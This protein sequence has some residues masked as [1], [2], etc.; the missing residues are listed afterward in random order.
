MNEEFIDDGYVKD[1]IVFNVKTEP[2]LT[3]DETVRRH[4]SMS[5]TVLFSKKR[6]PLSAEKKAELLKEFEVVCVNDYGDEYHMSEEERK[7]KFQ[8]Y[9]AF[10]KIIR[11]KRKYRK[12]DEFVKV[13][14]LCMD[15]LEIVANNNGV[16][17]PEKFTQ[18]VLKGDIVVSGLNFPKYIGKD[19]KTINW[20]YVTEFITDRTLDPKELV[21]KR[22]EEEV[23]EDN[24]EEIQK[25]L[26]TDEEVQELLEIL[27]I[28][29]EDEIITFYDPDD[30]NE[31]RENIAVEASDKEVRSLIKMDP[32]IL[33]SVKEYR[34]DKRRTNQMNR[35][36]SRLGYEYAYDDYEAIEEMDKE[37][38]IKSSGQIPDVSGDMLNDKE[39]KKY[40]RKLDDYEN[41][42]IKIN[43]HGKMRSQ[44]EI[45]EIELKNLLEKSGWN[46]KNMFSEQGSISRKKLKKQRK[47]DK[48]R[49]EQLKK[50]LIQVQNRLGKKDTIDIGGSKK[51]SKKKKKKESD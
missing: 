27:N 26:F 28:D 20:T 22:K 5:D 30:P 40:L 39:Y 29:D 36:I 13:F 21:T 18:L 6:R 17:P 25:K 33:L 49:E 24:I 41:D 34:K 2:T 51:K 1:E 44:N 43:Y 15:C 37:R 42:C 7:Q 14:R 3:P 8:F 32:Q 10:A 16:Y 47:A 50:R 11:C 19:K 46:V 9:E 38:K 4:S 31:T 12:L 35:C 45:D 48:R 23:D